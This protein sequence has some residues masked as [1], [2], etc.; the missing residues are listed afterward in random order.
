MPYET[1][2]DF[3]ALLGSDSYAP[4]PR[5]RPGLSVVVPQP[6]DLAAPASMWARS[7]DLFYGVPEAV[8]Q[9]PAGCYRPGIHPN[10]GPLLSLI[11]IETDTLVHLPDSVTSEVVAEVRAF[12]KLGDR[13]RNL[14]FLHKR[15]VMLWGPPGS[16]KTVAISQIIEIIVGEESGIAIMIDDPESA[17]ACLQLAR[18]IEPERPILAI[19]EDIDALTE[20]YGEAPYLAL[21]DGEAQIDNVVFVATTNYPERLS[22]RFSDRPSR[23]DTVRY[24][25]MPSHA[26][27]L[28]YLKAK[29]PQLNDE[30][31]KLAVVSDGFS[32]AHLRELVVLYACFGYSIESS[33]ARL[34]KMKKAKPDSNRSPEHQPSGFG[35]WMEDSSSNG[36]GSHEEAGSVKF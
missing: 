13:F 27:R 26:A 1:D 7:R 36:D 4:R 18:R 17:V 2:P 23:F 5:T 10:Y 24:V 6:S 12:R 22:N 3:N 20:R 9:I 30:A 14:G 29:L 16:G 33:A 35:V 32:I 31:E 19:L 28:H 25:G 11:N 21:L 8:H 15:G 34:R